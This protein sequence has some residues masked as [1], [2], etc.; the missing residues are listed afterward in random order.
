MIY[1]QSDSEKKLPHHFDAACALYGAQDSA[2]D[3]RL[4]SF[5]EIASGKF[6]S[7]IK[8][9]LCVGSV[10]FM[11]E[12]FKRMNILNIPKVPYNS[13]RPCGIITLS[14]ARKS[15]SNDKKIFIKP[16][17]PK[18]FTGFVL[19]GSDYTCLHDLPDDTLVMVYEPFKNKILSEWRVYIH[20]NK[21]V[22]LKNYSGEFK[23]FPHYLFIEK[24]VEYNKNCK[25]KFP[26]AYTMDIGIF[27]FNQCEVIE[28]NDMWA[29]GNY[30]LPNDLY[31]RLLKDRYFEIIRGSFKQI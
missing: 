17:Q 15:I 5:E 30:G 29:I 1:I 4:T 13:N 27:D 20:N 25:T 16:V 9:N 23:F 19:D 7:L 21:V 3:F 31:L 12:V 6:D 8:Q 26:C 2:L 22:D 14:D 28:Y 18:L 10:E 24:C 11:C